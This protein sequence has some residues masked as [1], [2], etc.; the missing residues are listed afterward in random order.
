MRR[1]IKERRERE[2]DIRVY[3]SV[4]NVEHVMYLVGCAFMRLRRAACVYMYAWP[5]GVISTR[6]F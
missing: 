4:R 3:V 2:S 5:A 6:L 1:K